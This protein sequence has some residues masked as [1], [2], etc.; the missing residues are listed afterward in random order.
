[1]RYV[2]LQLESEPANEIN[3]EDVTL[4]S[5]VLYLPVKTITVDNGQVNE[6]RDDE[7]RNNDEPAP[8]YNAGYEPSGSF[9]TRLYPDAAGQV[10]SAFI[11]RPTTTAGDGTI[12][13]LFE[14][15]VPVGVKRHRWTSPFKSDL[16][17][18]SEL[19]LANTD[20]GIF[21]K[22]HGVTITDVEVSQDS[23][24]AVIIKV[25]FVALWVEDIVDPE[26]TP[27]FESFSVLPLTRNQTTLAAWEVDAEEVSDF[28][29][30]IESPA[31]VIKSYAVQSD[32][33]DVAQFK[34][35]D[36]TTVTGQV[37]LRNINSTTVAT[38]KDA[39]Q[40]DA[41]VQYRSPTKVGGTDTK[42]TLNLRLNAV[43]YTGGNPY[44]DTEHAQR[45]STQ[46]DW[47]AV[48]N[49]TT[50]AVDIELLNATA[51]YA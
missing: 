42:Y 46:L 32:F 26:L 51:S 5:K 45:I 17:Q 10:L 15:V 33:P 30:K 38:M 14:D 11:G 41:G 19:L 25:S 24:Q 50:N 18:T 1:M 39:T 23:N 29:V 35:Q 2:K 37:T 40:F 34:D 3:A 8:V 49:G 20:E 7:L 36:L 44:G 27:T 28:S 47:K 6:S 4:G 12:T 22:A 9:E 16:P 13:D 21:V 48:N 31:E 43:Q